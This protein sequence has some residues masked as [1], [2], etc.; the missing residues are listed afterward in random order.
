MRKEFESA[1]SEIQNLRSVPQEVILEALESALVTAYRRHSGLGMGQVIEATVD[2]ITGRAKILV[3]K[4]VVADVEYPP[5][6]VSLE[7]ARFYNPDAQIGDLVMV[8]FPN[9]AKKFS[10]IAAQSAKQIILQKINEAERDILYEEFYNREGDI[11]N[12]TVQ[13]VSNGVVSL[14]LGRAEAFMPKAHQIQNEKYRQ[15]D[16]LRVYVTEVRKT[17]RGPQIIVS[18]AHREMLKR[19]LEFEVP[20]IYNGQVEIRSV[21]REPGRRSK[22][23]VA[24]L[25]EGIDPVGACVGVRGMRIQNIVHELSDEKIDVI[26]WQADPK[27]FITRS[28]SPAR[29]IDVYLEETPENDRI[30]V[31]VVQEDQLSLAI[32]HR[33]QNA[34]LTAKLTGWRID[35]RSVSDVI[36]DTLYDPHASSY[37]YMQ[38]TYADL[39]S[40]VNRIREKQAKNLTIISEDYKVLNEFA[41]HAQQYS[42]DDRLAHNKVRIAHIDQLREELPSILFD[43]PITALPCS[44]EIHE[45]LSR[46]DNVGELLA[47]YLENEQSILRYLPEEEELDTLADDL[48]S[49][50]HETLEQAKA[51]T[52]VFDIGI[53]DLDTESVETDIIQVEKFV[54]ESTIPVVETTHDAVVEHVEDPEVGVSID[55]SEDAQVLEETTSSLPAEPFIVDTSSDDSKDK[56]SSRKHKRGKLQEAP[57]FNDFDATDPVKSDKDFKDKKRKRK[58]TLIYDEQSNRMVVKRRRKSNRKRGD[59]DGSEDIE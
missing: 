31:V 51:G 23:A 33:G 54:E 42:M 9:S 39:F 26:E 27:Q 45:D 13:N 53:D 34:R 11:I 44:P 3:E 46:F 12:A 6:E 16:R 4:E 32:G 25:Y 2:P 22:V 48:S 21:A 36:E 14:S 56:K 38:D 49:I 28:L 20:E 50:L 55:M 24:A 59:W 5:T 47:R 19:L 29:I 41:K 15:H 40:Q 7:D 1:F 8:E 18:R 52:L 57:D 35:I 37:Q 58:R 43:Y 10:R 17:A 30:A